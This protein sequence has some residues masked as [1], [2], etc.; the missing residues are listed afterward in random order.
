MFRVRGRRT[1]L[2][3]AG[4]MTVVGAL[5]SLQPSDAVAKSQPP[6]P[7]VFV[8]PDAVEPDVAYTVGSGRIEIYTSIGDNDTTKANTEDRKNLDW[9]PVNALAHLVDS[10]PVGEYTR[11]AI[12]NTYQDKYSA[13]LNTTTNKWEV[14]DPSGVVTD[15]MASITKAVRDQLNNYSTPEERRAHV[16]AIGQRDSLQTSKENGSSLADLLLDSGVMKLCSKPAGSCIGNSSGTDMHSKFGLFSKTRDSRGKLWS[17]VVTVTTANLNGTS[18]GRAANTMV[19]VYGDANLYNGLVKKVWEPMEAEK[20]SAGYWDA[21]TN[22][23]KGSLEGVT[24]YPSPRAKVSGKLVDFEFNFLKSKMKKYGGPTKYSCKIRIVHSMFSTGRQGI[25]NALKALKAEGCKIQT[26]LDKDFV[27]VLTK[28]YFAMSKW[29]GSIIGGIRYQNVHDKTMTMT[30]KTASG[31]YSYAAFTGSANFNGPGLTADES[32]I[33]I[34][35]ETGVAAISL[36]ADRMYKMAKYPAKIPVV[37]V[38]MSPTSKTLMVDDTAKLTATIAPSNA[39]VKTLQWS[40]SDSSVATV[41]SSGTVTAIS[42]GT[43]TIRARAFSGG[44]SATA[45]ITVIPSN[46]IPPPTITSAPKSVVVGSTAT[47]TAGW[48]K[49]DYA[50]TMEFQYLKPDDETWVS[51]GQATITNGSATFSYPASANR[52]WR[53]KTVS[54]TT[55]ADA[56]L[57]DAWLYSTSAT[58]LARPAASATPALTAPERFASNVGVP[59]VATWASPYSGKPA[60]L[61]LQYKTSTG[62]WSTKSKVTIASGSTSKTFTLTTPST[63]EWRLIPTSSALPS[64]VAAKPSAS[65]VM[66]TYGSALGESVP[67]PTL[68]A[69]SS[70]KKGASATFTAGWKTPFAAKYP[71]ELALQYKSGTGWATKFRLTIPAGSTTAKTSFKITATHTWRVVVATKS[72]PEGAELPASKSVKVSVR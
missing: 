11:L 32:V 4:V 15:S 48:S 61:A 2:L 52:I 72:A 9:R 71:A 64:G 40:T 13:A 66:T 68:S 43:A 51:A 49:S 7:A 65:V 39:S 34:T 21:A 54:I 33:K 36:H 1:A 26:V 47:I 41:S 35:Q 62:S 8:N 59:V 12:Y 67:R 46:M 38:S 19:V 23:I 10:V 16:M 53:A 31:A 30:Y 42:A 37:S 20:A 6:D 60:E 55:P 45:T 29:L 63:H 69:P 24:Y 25:G 44:Y 27:L 28:N 22:G 56:I 50:G 3:L 18:G 57:T 17:D 58:V 5:V 14:R 70:I